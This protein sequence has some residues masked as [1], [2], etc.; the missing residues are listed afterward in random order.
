M[1][2]DTFISFLNFEQFPE[3]K[4]AAAALGAGVS[5]HLKIENI[6][7]DENQNC[8][9]VINVTFYNQY[10]VKCEQKSEILQL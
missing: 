6:L 9:I 4:T 1:R 10:V 2:S 7:S 5:S 3:T 8:K